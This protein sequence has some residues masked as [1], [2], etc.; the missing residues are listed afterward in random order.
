MND[1][2]D[3]HPLITSG[4]EFRSSVKN[5]FKL[6]HRQITRVPC[7][8]LNVLSGLRKIIGSLCENR[9]SWLILTCWRVS[10][11]S[12]KKM[13]MWSYQDMDRT[14]ALCTQLLL[15]SG[16]SSR[17]TNCPSS[18][19]VRHNFTQWSAYFA[20]VTRENWQILFESRVLTPDVAIIG[21]V[22]WKACVYAAQ[23]AKNSW[24]RKS[25]RTNSTQHRILVSTW[26]STCKYC[27]PLPIA[28]PFT[29][30]ITETE[31]RSAITRLVRT[32]PGRVDRFVR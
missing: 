28:C 30:S 10:I 20:M 7:S 12:V 26:R 25:L 17:V 31:G 24:L 6:S 11:I 16:L 1:H 3:A 32:R 23:S 22:L 15:N 18:F 8:F 21:N 9:M 19:G 27:N 5:L 29:S 4:H 2:T 13:C 14:G